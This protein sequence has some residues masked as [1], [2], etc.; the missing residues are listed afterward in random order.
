MPDN[1][2]SVAVAIHVIEHFY[3]WEAKPLLEEWKRVLE[4]GGTLILELPCMDKV[5]SYINR[6]MKNKQPVSPTFSWWA[7]W[8]DPRELSV[9]M[10]HK[11]GYTGYMMQELLES[12]GF[13]DIEQQ[14]PLYH[15]KE[16]DMRFVCKKP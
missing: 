14:E 7:F 4:P 15:F 8:G 10:C 16:R 5:L 2:A 6:S 9:P 12:A 11:W 3:E 1:Y 13:I